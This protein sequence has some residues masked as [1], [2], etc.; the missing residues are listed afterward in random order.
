MSEIRKYLESTAFVSLWM[1][2]GW[3]FHDPY[4]DAVLH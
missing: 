1:L 4:R 2:A 3:F